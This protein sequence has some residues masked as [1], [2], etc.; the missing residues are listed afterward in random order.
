MSQPPLN[1][2][3]FKKTAPVSSSLRFSQV[4]NLVKTR[5]KRMQYRPALLGG[6]L[7]C[8]GLDLTPFL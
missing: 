2:L 6:F 1:S 7:A 3:Q 5:L 8:T 4:L